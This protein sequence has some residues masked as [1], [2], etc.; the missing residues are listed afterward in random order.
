MTKQIAEAK[1]KFNRIEYI[2]SIINFHFHFIELYS[3]NE[4]AQMII[5]YKNNN[6]F[7]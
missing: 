3:N 4:V 5:R 1:C 7:N 2:L 6:T